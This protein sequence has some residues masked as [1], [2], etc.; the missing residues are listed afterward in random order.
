MNKLSYIYGVLCMFLLWGC[1]TIDLSDVG[2]G[3]SDR[4]KSSDVKEVLYNASEGCWITECEGR[5]FF[6]QFSKDG[7]V[8]LDSDFLEQAIEVKT[9]FA[10]S[11][12]AVELTIDKCNVHFQN[13]SSEY[14]DTKFMIT[15]VP[16]VDATRAEESTKLILVGVA[17]GRKMELHTVAKSYIETKVAPKAEFTELF[18]KNLLDNQVICDASGNLIGYYSLALAG[19]S[20]ISVKIVTLENKSGNDV[21]GHTQY[22]ESMLVK[23]GKVFKLETPVEGIK[24]LDGNT[25]A[26]KAI[27][28]SGE[29]VAVEGMSGVTFISNKD[30]VTDFDYVTAG[31]EFSFCKEQNKGAA[32]DEIWECTKGSFT[33]GGTIADINLMK[34]D[35]GWKNADCTQRP[36]V[37]WSWWFA[38]LAFRSSEPGSNIRMNNVDKD[39]IHFTNLSGEG[40]TC[41]GGAM[42]PNQ[43]KDMNAYTKPLLDTWFNEKGLFVIRYDRLNVAGDN[44]FYIYLLCP[45]TGATENGGMWMKMQRKEE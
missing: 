27:D 45:D 1:N 9:T 12:K 44:K 17:T 33:D 16:A 41:G 35:Y 2:Y 36:L 8:I 30:A 31:K 43:V 6:F 24:A 26:F 13:L 4:L 34:Y 10:T 19:V 42:N 20:D 14:V 21:N 39:W 22:Y 40:E 32:C 38:N 25:Y 29:T 15:E 3:E 11:G 5:E 7:T 37:I 28:C 18:A 23:E